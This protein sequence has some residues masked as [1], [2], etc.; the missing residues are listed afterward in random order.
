MK[1]LLFSIY[2][3]AFL[4]III[5]AVDVNFLWLFGNSPRIREIKDPEINLTSELLSAD[6]KLIGSLFIENRTPIEY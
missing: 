4:L 6:G 5:L 1:G 3:L 2:S